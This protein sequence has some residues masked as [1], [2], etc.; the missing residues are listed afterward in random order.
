MNKNRIKILGPTIR[1]RE[2][3]DEVIGDIRA[4]T[5]ERNELQA[6]AEACHK[7]IDDEYGSE[8]AQFNKSLETK[9]EQVKA[10][11]EANGEEFG[12]A[13]TLVTTHGSVGWRLGMWQCDKLP[14][15][16]WSRTKKS[17]KGVK[18]VLDKVREILGSDYVR[19][20]EEVDKDALIAARGTLTAAQLN[21]VGVR[22]FQEE[23]FF[24]DPKLDKIE[25]RQTA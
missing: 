4:L 2:Q 1:T 15:W 8:L 23:G 22:I 6:K 13:R 3:L 9:T 19:V 21:S 24:V 7:A 18:A 10:W 25:N 12:G 11:A 17:A 16:I 14:G 5:I 20:K